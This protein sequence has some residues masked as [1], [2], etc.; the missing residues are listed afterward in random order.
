MQTVQI[1]RCTC[2]NRRV[3]GTCPTPD[4]AS[5]PVPWLGCEKEGRV[6]QHVFQGL[7]EREW[8]G[9]KWVRVTD[10]TVQ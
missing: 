9:S 4:L 2:G 1:W 8:S 6:R 5:N 7:E 3:W 10:R